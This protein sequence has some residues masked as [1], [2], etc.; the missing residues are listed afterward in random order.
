[1]Y[2]HALYY[3][4][5]YNKKEQKMNWIC[6]VNQKTIKLFCT[7]PLKRT[8][9]HGLWTMVPFSAKLLDVNSARNW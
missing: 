8:T 4:H 9:Q 5:Q 7:V 3:E 2:V 1:M 6:K